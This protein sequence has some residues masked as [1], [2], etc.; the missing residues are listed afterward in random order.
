MPASLPNLGVT[1]YVPPIPR[2]PWG[3]VGPAPR[4][5]DRS[6]PVPVPLLVMGLLGL[7]LGVFAA[8]GGR[9]G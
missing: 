6:D 2:E 1:D 4:Y 5:P 8:R 3:G 9:R 7:L